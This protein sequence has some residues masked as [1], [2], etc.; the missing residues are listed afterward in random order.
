MNFVEP[1]RD[2]EIIYKIK[3]DLYERDEKFFIMFMVGI[4]LG[5]RIGEILSLRVGDV[6]G[7][8]ETTIRQPKTGK[9]V[10]VAFNSELTRALEHY[11]NNRDPHEA[12][13][14]L[15]TNE[16]K[17][18]NRSWAYIVLNQVGRKY[19]LQNIGTHSMRKTCGYHYYKQTKDIATLMVW[20]NH[21]SERET[22]IYIG[23]TR[24]RIKKAMVSFKI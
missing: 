1:I 8:K 17:A 5:L 2:K 16:Y 3:K 20:F 21:T 14:P 4:N 24:E 22:L 13:I 19:G 11:C 10:S 9:E 18:I 7:K 12:L 23:I 15:N 6:K